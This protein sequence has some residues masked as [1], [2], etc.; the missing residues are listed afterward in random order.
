MYCQ[1]H[2]ETLENI[3]HVRI[4]NILKRWLIYNLPQLL[5]TAVYLLRQITIYYI[6]IGSSPAWHHAHRHILPHSP[7]RLHLHH[8]VFMCNINTFPTFSVVEYKESLE[9]PLIKN[10]RVIFCTTTHIACDQLC[11][12]A[13]LSYSGH[14][15]THVN[16]LGLTYFTDGCTVYCSD[17]EVSENDAIKIKLS[18]V[19]VKQELAVTIAY[20]EACPFPRLSCHSH[21]YLREILRTKVECF[22]VSGVF[23]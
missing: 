14:C 23:A 3:I 12:Y 19:E 20:L 11:Y 21:W 4:N 13:T 15:F 22:C 17:D 2:F 7:V 1:H 16:V 9:S 10:T 18:S 5:V 8:R 6:H